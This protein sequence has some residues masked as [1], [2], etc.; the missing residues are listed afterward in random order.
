LWFIEKLLWNE[1][2]WA[3]LDLGDFRTEIKRVQEKE[4]AAAQPE[5]E[6]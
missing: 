1:K 4:T 5:L 2:G 3:K 6:F